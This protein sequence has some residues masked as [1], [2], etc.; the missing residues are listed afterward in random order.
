MPRPDDP[1]EHIDIHL[2]PGLSDTQRAD[3]EQIFAALR[4]THSNARDAGTVDRL[5]PLCPALLID[6][7]LCLRPL[8]E[9]VGHTGERAGER[10]HPGPAAAE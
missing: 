6:G 10:G 3:A 7:T 4:A 5:K 9:C 1:A 2:A 8:D